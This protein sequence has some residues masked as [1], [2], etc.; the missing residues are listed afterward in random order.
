MPHYYYPSLGVLSKNVMGGVRYGTLLNGRQDGNTHPLLSL[1]L[2]LATDVL[3]GVGLRTALRTFLLSH[4][5]LIEF[6][7]GLEINVGKLEWQPRPGMLPS[8]SSLGDTL[9]AQKKCI[10]KIKGLK[11][12]GQTCYANSVMQALASIEPLYFYLESLQQLRARNNSGEGQGSIASALFQTLQYVNGHRVPSQRNRITKNSTSFLPFFFFSTNGTGDARRV[13]DIVAKHHSQFR[14]RGGGM[15]ASAGMS[16]QQDSHEFFSALMDVLSSEDRGLDATM[17]NRKGTDRARSEGLASCISFL[18]DDN[19]EEAPDD[20]CVN[21]VVKEGTMDS[22][23]RFNDTNISNPFVNEREEEKKHDEQNVDDG[24]ANNQIKH[25]QTRE[26]KLNTDKHTGNQSLFTAQA[27]NLGGTQSTIRN[28]F[29]GWSGSTIK[30]ATCRHIRPIRSTPF[31]GL[32]LPIANIQ[33]EFLEDFLAAE[34][35]GFDTAEFVSDVQ[36]FSCA[37]ARR[38]EELEE[39]EML[40]NGAISSVRRRCGGSTKSEKIN[41]N[42]Q[43]EEAGGDIEGLLQESQRIKSKITILQGL[44]PDADDDKLDCNDDEQR[45]E[46]ELGIVDNSLPPI[47]PLRGDAYKASLVMRPPEAL[48]IH[49]QRRHYDLSSQRM[50]K[51]SRHVQFEQTLDIRPYCAYE[52]PNVPYRLMSVIE[53]LGTAFGGHY[54]TYRRLCTEGGENDGWVL[55]SDESVSSR[56]WEDVRG[57]QAY[58]LFYVASREEPS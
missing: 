47:A 11:N 43:R 28:P 33:S 55:V 30:C 27:G 22:K 12:R 2:L 17:S 14:S 19:G 23:S 51:V 35:G 39:E 41:G 3:A 21:D 9:E 26:G 1:L 53:H 24:E 20:S 18:N 13:M 52:M 32:S 40:L 56:T 31:L 37:I 50:V 10:I 45:R 38:M 44:D 16:E 36:C 48:C 15:A 58:M 4:V 34:Y 25:I 6:S 29:D 57:C 49:I 54:Q 7:T 5:R 8:S 42:G 46:A